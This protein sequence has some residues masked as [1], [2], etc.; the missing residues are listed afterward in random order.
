MEEKVWYEKVNGIRTGRTIAVLFEK[1]KRH[2]G[3]SY[4]SEQDQFCKKIGRRIA[5]GRAKSV[6]YGKNIDHGFSFFPD[7]KPYSI[8]E[9][10]YKEREV[11]KK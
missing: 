1:N 9:W 11:Y 4:C 7:A 6:M 8:P 10:L 2:V 3:F 5:L